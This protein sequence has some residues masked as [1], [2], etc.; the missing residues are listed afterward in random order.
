MEP[1]L[2]KIAHLKLQIEQLA[3]HM[4]GDADR[5]KEQLAQV[6]DHP[7]GVRY[8]L[9]L[10]DRIKRDAGWMAQNYEEIAR[11]ERVRGVDGPEFGRAAG[12]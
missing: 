7:G 2:E 11:L 8:V 10:A 9:E 6:H 3:E 5:I 1:T 4:A 12:S